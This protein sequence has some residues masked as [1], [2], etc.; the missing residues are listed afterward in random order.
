MRVIDRWYFRVVRDSKTSDRNSGRRFDETLYV[1]TK[2]LIKMQEEQENRCYYCQKFMD[3]ISR[4]GVHGLTLE[5]LNN[6]LPHH[7]TNCVLCCKSCN[8]QK[9][10]PE[11]GVLKRTASLEKYYLHEDDYRTNFTNRR[12]SLIT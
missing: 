9:M 2:D 1:T 10:T 11:Q 6:D 8:S 7:R 4:R 5:R 3:W 12:C